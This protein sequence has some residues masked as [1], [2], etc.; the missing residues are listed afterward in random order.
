MYE[1]QTNPSPLVLAAAAAIPVQRWINPNTEIPHSVSRAPFVPPCLQEGGRE[2]VATVSQQLT[3]ASYCQHLLTEW[4]NL[5]ASP[6]GCHSFSVWSMPPQKI[7]QRWGL[8]IKHRKNDAAHLQC[9]LPL[10]G[11]V[12]LSMAETL[13]GHVG[14]V[15]YK[16]TTPNSLLFTFCVCNWGPSH[17]PF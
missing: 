8:H 2:P 13:T 12:N 1:S 15:S 11:Q 17:S 6:L 14:V 16:K 4:G 7:L 3:R 5:P 10:Q 9:I